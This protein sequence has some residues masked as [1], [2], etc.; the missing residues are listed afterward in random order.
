MTSTFV[1]LLSHKNS[2]GE[3][4]NPRRVG[5]ACRVLSCRS[6]PSAI[7]MLSVF[8]MLLIADGVIV[9]FVILSLLVLPLSLAARK[10]YLRALGGVKNDAHS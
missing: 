6:K 4:S 1:V 7:A 5:T 2:A 9:E 10:G 8:L 3:E